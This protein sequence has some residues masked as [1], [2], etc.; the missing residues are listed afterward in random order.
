MSRDYSRIV[1]IAPKSYRTTVLFDGRENDF[2][3]RIRGKHQF[4]EAG[5]LIVASSQQ[6]RIF[7]VDANG[8]VILEIINSKPGDD[9]FNYVVSQ[10]IWLPTNAFEFAEDMSCAN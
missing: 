4:T 9:R 7:E 1:S 8:K 2:Y 10:A 6:G 5:N 3:S